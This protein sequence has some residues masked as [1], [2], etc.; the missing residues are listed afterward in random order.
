[1]TSAE[2]LMWK[3][4]YVG[5]YGRGGSADDNKPISVYIPVENCLDDKESF[6]FARTVIALIDATFKLNGEFHYSVYLFSEQIKHLVSIFVGKQMSADVILS[7]IDSAVNAVVACV[8]SVIVRRKEVNHSIPGIRDAHLG[9]AHEIGNAL[10][11]A[12]IGPV[13]NYPPWL[14]EGIAELISCIATVKAQYKVEHHTAV[15]QKQRLIEFIQRRIAALQSLDIVNGD[16]A[17]DF[18]ARLDPDW[19]VNK[20]WKHHGKGNIDEREKHGGYALCLFA[21]L[22]YISTHSD[23]TMT[24]I[25]ND[26][27]GS[28]LRLLQ[29]NSEAI[30]NMAVQEQMKLLQT[31]TETQD[32]NACFP[33]GSDVD[34]FIGAI[35][36]IEDFDG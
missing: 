13:I 35:V 32:L 27:P 1:M 11:V 23:L 4:V 19:P 3:E 28:L 22:Q 10:I 31:V 24:E 18:V 17:S 12:A 33:F 21:A 20:V 8:P 16:L 26:F 6:N 30:L 36:P 15:G 9:L 7:A 25:F 29:R 34:S 14:I 2:Q 5:R